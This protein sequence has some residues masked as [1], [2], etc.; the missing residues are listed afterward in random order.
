MVWRRPNAYINISAEIKF[1]AEPK[2]FPVSWGEWRQRSWPRLSRGQPC[3]AAR[4]RA[5]H[6]SALAR[7]Q[8]PL[9]PR[10]VCTVN[11]L[12]RAI[13][14][15][16]PTPRHTTWTPAVTANSDENLKNKYNRAA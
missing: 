15:C 14:R 5:I 16:N 11:A 6:A 4:E 10:G 9:R 7:K 13:V 3:R 8:P 1:D 2:P 12:P